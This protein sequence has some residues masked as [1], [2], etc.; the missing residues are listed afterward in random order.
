VLKHGFYNALGGVIRIG[1]SIII[2]PLLIRLIGIEDFGIW[3]L[4]S[5]IIGIATLA[6]GG[7]TIS[8]TFFLSKDISNNDRDGISETLT[9]TFTAMLLMSSIA[10]L[11]VYF[12]SDFFVSLF[13]H[14]PSEKQLQS[15]EAVKLGSFFLWAK[16]LQQ[17]LIGLIQA[18]EKYG[19]LNV[20]GVVQHITINLGLIIV[21]ISGG[22]VIE[23]MKWQVL[24][25]FLFLIVYVIISK[26]IAGSIR[27]S[28]GWNKIKAIAVFKYSSVAWLGSLGGAFFAQGDRLI[29]GSILDARNLGIYAAITSIASQINTLS[30]LPISPLLPKLTKLLAH[31]NFEASEIKK[32]LKQGVEIN[33]SI[34]F[35]LGSLIF[36]ASERIL[37]LALKQTYDVQ[38]N[39]SL[40]IVSIVYTIYSLNAVGY[41]TLYALNKT[42]TCTMIHLC[43]SVLSIS[44]IA[45][46]TKHM[47]L[48]GSAI[49]NCGYILTFLMTVKVFSTLNFRIFLLT[50]WLLF[51]FLWFISILLVNSTFYNLN[52]ETRI[53]IYILQVLILFSWFVG[54]NFMNKWKAQKMS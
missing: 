33:A 4:S 11:T 46:L 48:S 23:M 9:L 30:A 26:K 53:L 37:E 12:G 36:V 39:Q 40:K 47:G 34:A 24:Q 3:T 8:T 5:S 28:L 27:L 17:H 22:N 49:G 35:F 14:L 13:P 7:L 29:V 52:V 21:A 15:L 42:K 25:G 45:L 31:K 6:E 20:L 32:I 19:S 51:P 54:V 16:L 41:Y 2:V 44:L 38:V 43:S 10:A 18:Y 1:L 50:K